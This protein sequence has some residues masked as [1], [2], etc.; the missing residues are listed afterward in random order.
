MKIMNIPLIDTYGLALVALII[1]DLN[2]NLVTSYFRP[3]VSHSTILRYFE[4]IRLNAIIAN[5]WM[6][7][8]NNGDD[9]PYSSINAFN[10]SIQQLQQS[11]VKIPINEFEN[12]LGIESNFHSS[13]AIIDYTTLAPNDPLFLG[14]PWPTESGPESSAIAKHL[15]WKRTL[16]DGERLRWQKWAVYDRYVNMNS[17]EFI[18]DDYISQNLLKAINQKASDSSNLLGLADN[19]ENILWKSIA[20]A[21]NNDAS[22]EIQ[23]VMKSFYTAINRKNTDELRVLWL[24]CSKSEITLPGYL[25]ARSH[26][27]VDGLYR[28]ALKR[29]IGS[30]QPQFISIQI[31]GNIA[32]VIS[33]E[34]VMPPINSKIVNKRN[35]PTSATTNEQ[36]SPKSS[37][38]Y[39]KLLSTT[40]LRRQNRQWRVLLHSTFRFS[41]SAYT[42][43]HL[44]L[45]V[46]PQR[47]LE[48]KQNSNIFGTKEEAVDDINQLIKSSTQLPSKNK[49]NIDGKWE[50]VINIDEIMSK[51]KATLKNTAEIPNISKLNPLARK[52][53]DAVHADADLIKQTVQAIR[54]LYKTKRFSYG[55]KVNLIDEIM[56]SVLREKRSLVEIAYELLAQNKII[57]KQSKSKATLSEL[58]NEFSAFA[59]QCDIIIE[60]IN[61]NQKN[62]RISKNMSTNNRDSTLRRLADKTEKETIKTIINDYGDEISKTNDANNDRLEM[63]RLQTKDREQIL[64]NQYED[65]DSKD[66]LK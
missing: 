31:F 8:R 43:N 46:P 47:K 24:P 49:L 51:S 37:V 25:T 33:I 59:N 18:V 53:Y 52:K 21:Y 40:I 42:N 26:G 7:N 66:N 57:E 27:E 56:E 2:L 64:N 29:V 63:S 19:S 10:E 34:T 39:K 54:F 55:D 1:F 6:E 45:K 60:K 41:T 14:M 12:E 30:I 35:M 50:K 15:L 5:R 20:A 61:K 4:P 28:K 3:T 32:K 58:S 65:E 16:S 44:N 9:D 22:S 13:K 23:S 36:I 17:A 11:N 62:N 48:N 38:N